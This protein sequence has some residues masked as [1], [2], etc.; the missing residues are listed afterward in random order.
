[1]DSATV[2]TLLAAW[3]DAAYAACA[4]DLEALC[5]PHWTP[6]EP[7][8]RSVHRLGISGIGGCLRKL[9]YQATHT[10]VSD[11][12]AT[13]VP[14]V[15]AARGTAAHTVWLPALCAQVPG[16][17]WEQPVEIDGAVW[18]WRGSTDAVLPVP[19]DTGDQLWIDYDFKTCPDSKLDAWYTRR[20]AATHMRQ[21][22]GYAAAAELDGWPVDWC[23]LEYMGLPSGRRVRWVWE[24]T[25]GAFNAVLER[26]AAVDAITSAGDA[27][28]AA[29][30][31]NPYCTWC[32][33]NTRCAAVGRQEA[34]RR[35]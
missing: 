33:W 12:P 20:P 8:P 3:S 34:I 7:V 9:G 17:L 21:V 11:D 5:A 22:Q 10:P 18:T 19:D 6:P 24:F 2:E 29:P 16:S 30:S 4:T 35:N 32:A 26:V 28:A 15:D 25:P 31:P 27:D 1:M 13:L 14:S 23:A